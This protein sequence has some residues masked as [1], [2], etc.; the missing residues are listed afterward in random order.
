MKTDR[1]RFV[2]FLIFALIGIVILSGISYSIHYQ[3]NWRARVE[4]SVERASREFDA[5]NKE[6]VKAAMEQFH[7]EQAEKDRREAKVF[8]SLNRITND[9][10][11]KIHGDA[12][13]DE[14]VVDLGFGVVKKM[15]DVRDYAARM[16]MPVDQA[17]VSLKTAAEKRAIDKASKSLEER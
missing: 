12:K 17:I 2:Q 11:E 7:R 3:M 14:D 9:L 4:E 8:N 10:Q 1:F 13:A 16:G 5:R 6:T 15:G